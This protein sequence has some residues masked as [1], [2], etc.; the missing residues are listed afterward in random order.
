MKAENGE[1]NEAD[2]ARA[3]MW[4]V[5][6]FDKRPSEAEAIVKDTPIAD[7]RAVVRLIARLEVTGG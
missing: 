1:Q 6:R 7:V 3:A 2:R 5:K 4:L